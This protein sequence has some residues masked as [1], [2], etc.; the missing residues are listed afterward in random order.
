[1]PKTIRVLLLALLLGPALIWAQGT[2]NPPAPPL[3]LPGIAIG[4]PCH[5]YRES[6]P[7]WDCWYFGT[8][9]LNL[10][11][12]CRQ[13]VAPTPTPAPTITPKP[14]VP[15]PPPTPTPTPVVTPT[16]VPTPLPTP[17]PAPPTDSL[18]VEA[19]AYPMY[20]VVG[21]ACELWHS[22]GQEVIPNTWPPQYRPADYRYPLLLAGTRTYATPQQCGFAAAG[23]FW[24]LGVCDIGWDAQ[25]GVTGIFRAGTQQSERATSYLPVVNGAIGARQPGCGWTHK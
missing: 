20:T 7:G 22:Y 9:T 10:K 8:N 6:P 12:Y 5:H 19:N 4:T 13:R 18:P 21:G 11:V 3:P 1:M 14:T 24:R 17:T 23:A 25:R 2:C 16:P 15:P